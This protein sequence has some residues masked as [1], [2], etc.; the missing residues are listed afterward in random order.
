MNTNVFD[1]ANYILSKT[2]EISTMKLQKLVFYC[3]AWS[4]VWDE[5]Q[6]FDEQIEAWANGP[7]VPALYQAHKG[8]F[9]IAN[10]PTGDSSKFSKNQLETIDK[11]LEVLSPK[12]AK[13]L[14]DLTHMESPW[15][16]A[17]QG[18]STSERGNNIISLESIAEYYSSL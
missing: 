1:L 17:R 5:K 11:V 4:L 14:I 3:Q 6:L 2:G 18:L 16:N 9:T 7:V 15:L 13:W 12:P 8:M 10:L